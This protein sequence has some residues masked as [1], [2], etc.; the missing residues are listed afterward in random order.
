V[1]GILFYY[2]MKGG[3]IYE[4]VVMRYNFYSFYSSSRFR[5]GLR[6]ER[7]QFWPEDQRSAM[8][9]MREA[10][11]LRN[12]R[13]TLCCAMRKAMCEALRDAMRSMREALSEPGSMQEALPCAM[14]P[15]MRH[16]Y[17]RCHKFV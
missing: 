13:E 11:A 15:E 12:V 5:P 8:R 1:E 9:D 4:E 10:D 17:I 3:G 16:I 6:R 7:D 14:R 2:P